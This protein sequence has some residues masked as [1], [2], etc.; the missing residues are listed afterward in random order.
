MTLI[1]YLG[2]EAAAGDKLK[3][4][5]YAHWDSYNYGTSSTNES[6]FTALPGG[7]RYWFGEFGELHGIGSWWISD[8]RMISLVSWGSHTDFGGLGG[9]GLSVRCIKNNN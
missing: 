4:V 1:S 8:S 9:A 6:G 7:R 5:G 3:E 2:G